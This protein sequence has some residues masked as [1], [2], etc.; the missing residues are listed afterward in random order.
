MLKADALVN[1]IINVINNIQMLKKI[2]YLNLILLLFYLPCVSQKVYVFSP[3]SKSDMLLNNIENLDIDGK[4][5]YF[6][7]RKKKLSYFN[8]LKWDTLSN[9]LITLS[10]RNTQ[11]FPDVFLP[12]FSKLTELTLSNVKILK[13]HDF[14]QRFKTL[15]NLWIQD[16]EKMFVFDSNLCLP[17]LNRLIILNCQFD[18]TKDFASN[19]NISQLYLHNNYDIYIDKL[20]EN[21]VL[22]NKLKCLWNTTNI[23]DSLPKTFPRLNKLSEIYLTVSKDAARNGLFNV[24]Y[25]ME[26][27][28][29]LQISAIEE[30][31]GIDSVLFNPLIDSLVLDFPINKFPSNILKIDSLKYLNIKF[32]KLSKIPVEIYSMKKLKELN[33][34]NGDTQIEEIS[35]E[36]EKMEALEVLYFDIT[37]LK[38]ISP[39]I[40]RLNNLKLIVFL[41][42]NQDAYFELKRLLPKCKIQSWNSYSNKGYIL[43]L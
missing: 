16:C 37:N 19:S 27:I 3:F 21:I 34:I 24:L 43:G 26:S 5:G 38:K 39:K 13:L 29:I 41:G 23:I 15:N 35:D 17:N 33:I 4:C 18:I 20:L 30:V 12:K 2:I 31:S 7:L 22:F 8:I 9:F 10:V 1:K 25:N 42:S 36:I 14:N 28:R 40:S 11:N 6:G 32:N